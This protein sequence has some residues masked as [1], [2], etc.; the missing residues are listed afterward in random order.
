MLKEFFP[1]VT[2][3][4]PA[5]NA[6]KTIGAMIESV[7]AQTY[8]NW[9]LLIVDD[10]S[11]DNT[12]E[13]VRS[14]GDP[15]I[16]LI[17]DGKNRKIAPRLNLLVDEAK[18]E[19]FSRMDADD[20]MFPDRI[21]RQIRYLLEHPEVDVVGGGAIV[22]DEDGNILGSRD[23]VSEAIAVSSFIHPT[24]TGRIGWFR[25][26][27]YDE[28][29]N[30]C[31]DSELWRRARQE[32]VYRLLSGATIYYKDSLSFNLKQYLFRQ[33]QGARVA[34]FGNGIS[35]LE[36]GKLFVGAILRSAIAIGV[37]CLWLSSVWV[38]RRNSPIKQNKY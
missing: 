8:V 29:F 11:S 10:G 7:L 19:F 18:G 16:R 23:V 26:W 31:E 24:V 13:V 34:L 28:R 2:V 27:R 9:E 37:S 17:C 12:A 35:L 32:S 21:E 15:R 14:F 33:K 4:V 36:R 5:Y 6:E 30:G 25:K 3:A 20:R 22:V 1:L 38:K